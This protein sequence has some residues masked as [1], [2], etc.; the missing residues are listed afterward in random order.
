MR[1]LEELSIKGT[2]VSSL[3]Q[4]AKNQNPEELS[5]NRQTGL[6]LHRADPGRIAEG[7]KEGTSLCQLSAQKI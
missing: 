3:L 4:V 2:Q 6:Q 1:N 7:S 5:K